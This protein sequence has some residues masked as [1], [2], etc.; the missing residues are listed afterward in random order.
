ME[1]KWKTQK[2]MQ[3]DG[4]DVQDFIFETT[5]GIVPIIREH[6]IGINGFYFK[7]HNGNAIS[8]LGIVIDVISQPAP[9][10]VTVSCKQILRSGNNNVLYAKESWV[11]VTV[12]VV[13]ASSNTAVND[14]LNFRNVYNLSE[15]K[16]INQ[17]LGKDIV[18]SLSCIRSFLSSFSDKKD[19][20]GLMVEAS[21]ESSEKS[22]LIVRANFE[23]K[24]HKNVLATCN[25]LNASAATSFQNIHQ[26]E[27]EVHSVEINSGSGKEAATLNTTMGEDFKSRVEEGD[28]VALISDFNLQLNDSNSC[29]LNSIVAGNMIY[30]GN[31]YGEPKNAIEIQNNENGSKVSIFSNASMHS[32]YL[33]YDGRISQRYNVYSQDSSVTY[34]VL[35]KNTSK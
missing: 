33:G 20:A 8:Q 2:M 17:N 23:L 35:A 27:F 13:A 3:S 34:L 14:V 28:A 5:N 12:V 7:T 11:W 6:F 15:S 32:D 24:G 29:T 26:P 31:S 10:I 4:L 1:I 21:S 22:N 30:S 16:Y 9:N 25:Q 19:V 18:Q